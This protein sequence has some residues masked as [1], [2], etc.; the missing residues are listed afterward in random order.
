MMDSDEFKQVRYAFKKLKASFYY[1]KTAAIQKYKLAVY[2]SDDDFNNKLENL[3]KKMATSSDKTWNSYKKELINEIGYFAFPKKVE[4]SL[5]NDNASITNLDIISNYGPTKPEIN[6]CQFYINLPVEGYLFGIL[7]V[8]RIGALLDTKLSDNVYGNRVR[9]TKGYDLTVNDPTPYLFKPYFSQYENWRDK[10]IN[11]AERTIKHDKENAY[12]LSLDLSSFFYQVQYTKE[13]WD[14]I[15]VEVFPNEEPDKVDIRLHSFCF[16]VFSAYAK[17]LGWKS[18]D[19]DVSSMLPIGFAPSLVAANWCL[20]NFDEAV[21]KE[22][23]PLYYGRYVDDILIVNKKYSAKEDHPD[24]PKIFTDL[25]EKKNTHDQDASVEKVKN[26]RKFKINKKYLKATTSDIFFQSEKTKLFNFDADS[27]Y[28]MLSRL[29]DEI[30]KNSSEFKLMP[31]IY[32]LSIDDSYSV[33]FDYQFNGSPNKFRDIQSVKL[34]KYGFSKY[35]GC[36]QK[37]LPVLD[38]QRKKGL[39]SGLID[40][41]DNSL[42]IDCFTYWERI[43]EILICASDYDLLEMFVNRIKEAIESTIG[44]VKFDRKINNHDNVVSESKSKDKSDHKIKCSELMKDENFDEEIKNTLKKYLYTLTLRASVLVWN[45]DQDK[46]LQELCAGLDCDLYTDLEFSID[47]QHSSWTLKKNT[48]WKTQMFNISAIQVVPVFISLSLVQYSI[49]G[50]YNLSILDDVQILLS[51]SN[52]IDPNQDYLIPYVVKMQS[53]EFTL[54]LKKIANGKDVDNAYEIHMGAL[55]FYESF[56][57]FKSKDALMCRIKEFDNI[58]NSKVTKSNSGEMSNNFCIEIAANEHL[59]KGEMRVAIANMQ[60]KDSD[61]I[62]IFE[63]KNRVLFSR[64]DDLR[65]LTTDAKRCG[66]NMLVLPEA[67]VP[68]TLVPFLVKFAEKE[69]IAV[70]CGVE[71]VLGGNEKNKVYNLTATILPYRDEEKKWEFAK[72]VFHQKV[73]FSPKE[74]DPARDH[75]CELREGN[76][77]ELFSWKNVWFPVYCCFELASIRARSLFFSIPDLIVVP[78]WNSDLFYY[79]HIE[80][81]LARDLSCFCV[82]ANNAKYGDSCILQP[83][84]KD[85]ATLL[86]IKGGVNTTVLAADLK[87]S[88]L[89]DAQMSKSG[90]DYKPPSPKYKRPSPDYNHRYPILKNDGEMYSHL[91]E[92]KSDD[93]DLDE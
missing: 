79:E 75:G 52:D 16:D 63:K 7:W 57:Q 36:L 40:L 65:Q 43:I 86:R 44:P 89:R 14:S 13:E 37:V 28:A 38:D 31:D 10:A 53:I 49:D 41:F 87:I 71:H 29:K 69:D 83:K 50:I 68:L 42:I 56:N 2:E 4:N 12:L 19:N 30:R 3:Y 1:E 11:I 48:L 24:I 6:E 9:H 74:S 85:H 66:A 20:Y 39:L 55:S 93:D 81:S 70:I 15:L 60:L 84:G 51:E 26:N 91:C 58:E 45:S 61:L 78:V 82:E 23:N 22:V 54:Y 33:I 88:E 47:E 73:F 27:P 59:D 21:L 32:G 77:F 17:K 92:K 46:K 62:H 76:S 34:D 8:M 67:S 25:I 18:N 90:N 5:F 80:Y 64:Y 72:L 35:I